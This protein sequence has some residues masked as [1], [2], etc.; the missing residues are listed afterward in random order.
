MVELGS[1]FVCDYR[2]AKLQ[3]QVPTGIPCNST[4]TSSHC[5]ILF[6]TNRLLLL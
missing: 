2:S 1:V 5:F 6:Q 4:A 3:F